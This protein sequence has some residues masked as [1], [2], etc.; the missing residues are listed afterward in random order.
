MR[1]YFAVPP[2]H[3]ASS[4]AR[5][6]NQLWVSCVERGW[7]RHK[8]GT[9]PVLKTNA[10]GTNVLK[11][12]TCLAAGLILV[13][14]LL[15]H[16]S[17]PQR[18]AAE[19]APAASAATSKPITIVLL[20]VILQNDNEGLDPTSNAERARQKKV[21]DE[22]RRMLEASGR[23][24][25]VQ[26]SD[27]IKKKM[28]ISQHIGQCAG[29]ELEYGRQLGVD[30][31]AWVEVQKISNLILNLNV[32]VAGTKD[33]KLNFIHSVDIRGNTDESW[34]RSLDYLL[35]NFFLGSGS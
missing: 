35:K 11:T 8:K 3:C 29:C 17:L 13:A 6:S 9:S 12:K 10:I 16:T 19:E 7:F 25:F 5:P 32:Y 1:R 30:A 18:A 23:Y 34:V 28:A 26:V 20:D 15:G 2:L 22:F 31:V 14:L 27:D 21:G 4:R 24:K 33:P